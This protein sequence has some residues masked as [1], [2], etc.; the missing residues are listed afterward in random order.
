MLED[1]SCQ[2]VPN[3]DWGGGGGA[4]PQ[5]RGLSITMTA[6][7]VDNADMV[8]AIGNYIHRCMNMRS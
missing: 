3:K 2:L 6:V 7:P 5:T 8:Y 4:S 1:S